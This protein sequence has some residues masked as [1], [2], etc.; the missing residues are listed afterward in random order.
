MLL[1]L[2]AALVHWCAGV[3]AKL[4]RVCRA[5]NGTQDDKISFA[6]GMRGCLLCASSGSLIAAVS[7]WPAVGS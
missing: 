4:T 3:Y 7:H 1:P 2:G 5:L 6:R